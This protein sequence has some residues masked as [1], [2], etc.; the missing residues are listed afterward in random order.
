MSDIGFVRTEMLP[1]QAPPASEVGII[2]W[3]R[4]NLFDGWFNSALTLLSVYFVYKVLAALVPWILSP[5]W[6]A[7]SL[8]ECRE[9]LAGL[10]REG[11]Y[12]GA[13][14]GVINERWIQLIFGFYPAE[15]YW[16]PIA[17]FILLGVALA[18]VLFSD[19]VPAKLL[20]FSALYPFIFPWLLWGGTIWGPISALLGFVI[21]WLVYSAVDK[22]MSNLVGI[23][24]GTLAAVIWWLVLSGYFVGAM[25]TI[26]AIGIEPVESR[27]F[28]GF[29]LSITIGVVAIA[30]SLPLGIVLA[31]GRQSDLMIVKYLCVGFIEFIRGVPLIT[32]LFV[33]STLLNIFLPPG[34]DFDII[35]RVLIMV[36]LFASAYM[37]EVIR[38]GLAALPR[39]QYE[40]ADSL[41]LNYWQSQRLIIMP[42]A[43]KISIP[44][45]VSTFIGVFKDTTLVSIIGL[46]DPLG[47]SNAIRADANWNGIVWELYGFIAL[48]FFAFC[49]GMSR[50]SMY[51]ERKL[52][53]GHR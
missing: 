19:K 36:T 4:H 25:D 30:C 46:L 11:H 45:I 7:G 38:G 29:M 6:D 43:L 5:T 53:T 32:L 3:M 35:L 39:G 47:L 16:R 15:L 18:P 49:F 9:I 41:G 48:L 34:T 28:G 51:L 8:A 24:A 1:E 33:A 2:G 21:G 13:C 44:G 26:A 27:K 50:Y 31:L 17:A 52:H 14:W 22:A 42:Q 23:I 40:G 10:G 20:V 37:A 12:A